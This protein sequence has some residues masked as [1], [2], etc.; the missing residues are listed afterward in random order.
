MPI[1]GI[2]IK[3]GANHFEPRRLPMIKAIVANIAQPTAAPKIPPRERVY[4]TQAMPAIAISAKSSLVVRRCVPKS[5][6][7]PASSPA[8][9]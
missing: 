2:A 6:T 3:A 8:A 4:Q 5:A 7:A 9:M 1:N